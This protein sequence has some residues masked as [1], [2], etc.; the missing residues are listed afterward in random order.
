V[1]LFSKGASDHLLGPSSKLLETDLKFRGLGPGVD[2]NWD[3]SKLL[4]SSELCSWIGLV[5]RLDVDAISNLS[6]SPYPALLPFCLTGVP[7]TLSDLNF[8]GPGIA[9][10]L[11][12]G[13]YFRLRTLQVKINE[14]KDLLKSHSNNNNNANKIYMI[15]I[16]KIMWLTAL[17]E[18]MHHQCHCRHLECLW[19]LLSDSRP[20]LMVLEQE[21]EWPTTF[22]NT[23]LSE[24][25]YNDD[26]TNN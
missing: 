1:S 4:S 14:E 3:V 24:L 7:A 26:T 22:N 21:M 25:V 10:L 17:Q 5:P 8:L 20:F 6:R 12:I 9:R 18:S 2:A 11:G 13:I 19:N 23:T 16:N 15:R